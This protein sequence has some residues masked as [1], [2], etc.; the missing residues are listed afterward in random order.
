MQVVGII[1]ARLNSE[2][3][4]GKVLRPLLGRAMV[5]HVFDAARACDLLSDVRIATDSAV[6][7]DY[8]EAHQIPVEMTQASHRSGTE[9]IHEVMRRTPGDVFV[10]LQGDEPLLTAEHVRLLLEPFRVSSGVQVSTLKTPLDA[11]AA[12]SPHVVKVVTDVDG[13][14]LYFSRAAIPFHRSP[15]S[16]LRYFKHLGLYAYRREALERYMLLPASLLEET[17]KLEQLR[18][19]EHGIP[20]HVVETAQDT[21]GVDTEEDFHAA[22][23]ALQARRAARDRTAVE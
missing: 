23:A 2:R 7:C 5:H 19:L 13:R 15:A 8:C 12:A 11:A 16:R 17:E 1:P 21:I 10:N 22:E 14:A 18:F 4:P 3:L 20:I 6:V 9:R